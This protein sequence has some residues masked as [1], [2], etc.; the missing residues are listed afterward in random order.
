MASIKGAIFQAIANRLTNLTAANGYSTN[1]KQVYWD[2]IPMGLQLSV[3]QLPCI[4]LLDG[5]DPVDMKFKCLEGNW[6]IRLQLWHNG[7]IGDLEMLQFSRDVFKVIYANSPTAE[8][9]DQFRTLHSR[10]VEIVPL[11]ISPDLNM[12]DG[13]RVAELAFTVRYRTKLFD[14]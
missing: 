9:D 1:V 2:K 4:F 5:P 11:S 14:L 13:N 12:I 10:I 7:K 3:Q 6:D 8:V